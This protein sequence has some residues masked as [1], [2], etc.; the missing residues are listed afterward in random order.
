MLGNSDCSAGSSN[1]L[2]DYGIGATLQECQRNCLT[3][4]VCTDITWA[5]QNGHCKTFDGCENAGVYPA[6]HHYVIS[7]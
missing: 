5:P 3:L 7:G 2:Y 4:T 6:W 1:L